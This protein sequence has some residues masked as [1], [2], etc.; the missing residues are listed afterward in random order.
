MKIIGREKEQATLKQCL[1]SRSPE[2]LVVYGRRRVGKTF[3]I[4]EYFSGRFD[5][6]VTGLANADMKNQLKAWNI[7]L[8][9]SFAGDEKDATSWLDAF[10]LLRNMLE[11]TSK[12][13]KKVLFIDEIPWLDTPKSG[14]LTALE[15]FWNGWASGRTDILL[16]ICGSATSWVVNNIFKNR[17]GLYNRVT[18]RMRLLPF[19]LKE[20]EEFLKEK[21][22]DLGRYQIAEAYMIFGGVPYY[23]NLLR[24][25]QSLSQN[26]DSL[27]FADDGILRREFNELY[28]NLFKN[29]KH[30]VGVIT[31]LCAKTKG[32]TRD[33]IIVATGIASGGSLTKILDEL[34]LCGFIRSYPNFLSTEKFAIYKLT[35][36]FSSFYLHFIKDGRARNPHFW[37]TNLESPSLSAWKGFAFEKLC[38]AH[39]E[40]IKQTLGIAGVSTEISSWRS[41]NTTPGAQIDLLIDRKDG[42]INVCEIKFSKSEYSITAK[43]EELLRNRIAVFVTE[44]RTRKAVHITMVTSFGVV[45]NR[46]SSLIQSEVKLEDLFK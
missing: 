26:I 35:D 31:A 34:E 32:L 7:A 27:C 43:E 9:Q 13:K 19:N 10:S 46:H 40:Q 3:L 6:Y 24:R 22:I 45:Q 5:F 37:S 39:V 8:K 28:A 41:K 21:E 33:E 38:L 30:H 42:I 14:F 4:R 36:P 1:E 20:T 18:Q 44:T 23:Y 16:I 17:G 15:Y 29:S 25:G 11:K 2:F 12:S